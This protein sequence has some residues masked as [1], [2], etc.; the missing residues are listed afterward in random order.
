MLSDYKYIYLSLEDQV[1]LESSL[2]VTQT[3]A[4]EARRPHSFLRYK[5]RAPFR[6]LYNLV[7]RCQPASRSRYPLAAQLR[8]RNSGSF[9]RNSSEC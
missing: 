9:V 5:R 4:A 2:T 8:V 7:R 1:V 3:G 6:E